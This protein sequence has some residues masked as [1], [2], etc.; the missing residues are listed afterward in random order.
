MNIVIANIGTTYKA[1]SGVGL[2]RPTRDPTGTDFLWK[3]DEGNFY[4]VGTAVPNTVTTLTAYWAKVNAVAPTITNNLI[5]ADYYTEDTAVALSVLAESTDSGTITYQWFSNTTASI[6][7]GTAISGET[8]VTY[9]PPITTAG[10][11]YYYC[12]VTN[13]ITDNGDTGTKT[14]TTNSNVLL[15][16]WCQQ[17]QKHQILPQI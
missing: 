3:D 1:P 14:A 4:S 9:T 15:L 16:R 2:T 5:S 6:T 10:T 11:N 8:S 13:K 17:R 7:G 12:V